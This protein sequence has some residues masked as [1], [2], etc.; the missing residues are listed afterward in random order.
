MTRRQERPAREAGPVLVGDYRKLDT[1][2]SQRDRDWRGPIWDTIITDP[3]FGARTHAGARTCAAHDTQ[4]VVAYP[5]WTPDD[6]AEFVRWAVPR[7]R[8]WIAAMTS[9]DLIEAWK[10][11]YRAAGWY[12]FAP[13]PI[14]I[15][16]MGVRRQGDGPASW[17]LYLMTARARSRAAMR[18][19]ASNGTA[20]WRALPGGYSWTR[21]SKSAGQG[22][23]KPVAGLTELVRDYSNP[24]D[25]VCDP[26]AGHGSTLIA[27]LHSGR[28]AIGSDI[29][30]KAVRIANAAIA[31]GLDSAAP[32][33]AA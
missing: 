1:W 23:G 11:A 7:T 26:F 2:T 4:G 32:R 20:L 27:A 5:P 30:R 22:R 10:D 13:V 6:V 29:D 28:R 9:D 3:P 12:H 16:G 17:A 8:R 25:V 15:R 24:G 19:P 31:A 33:R 18:N 14:V 21:G